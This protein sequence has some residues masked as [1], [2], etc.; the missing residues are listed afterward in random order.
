MSDPDRDWIEELFGKTIVWSFVQ[1]VLMLAI[2]AMMTG[3]R[4]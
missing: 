2:I 1:T 4:W 3:I